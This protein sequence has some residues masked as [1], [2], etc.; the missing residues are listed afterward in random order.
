MSKMERKMNL[1]EIKS[2]ALEMLLYVDSICKKE[3]LRYS[4]YY[5]TL[6]GAVR[7]GG[8]IPWMMM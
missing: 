1:A 2:A 8:F 6:L 7:H 4:I 5:G 3:K